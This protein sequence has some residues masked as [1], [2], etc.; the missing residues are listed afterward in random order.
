MLIGDSVTLF[1]IFQIDLLYEGYK[2]S[3]MKEIPKV[4]VLIKWLKDNIP[5]DGIKP[6]M[7]R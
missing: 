5:K 3:E 7:K 4:P 6:G 1:F 2:R